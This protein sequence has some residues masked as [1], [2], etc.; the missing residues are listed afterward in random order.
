MNKEKEIM[1]S[2]WN[3]FKNDINGMTGDD[4]DMVV[5]LRNGKTI[6]INNYLNKEIETIINEI[7]QKNNK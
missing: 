3:H 4:N 5:S 7:T 2:L 1:E 6:T